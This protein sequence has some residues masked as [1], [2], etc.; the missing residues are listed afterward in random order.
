MKEF[1]EL[2][3]SQIVQF[4]DKVLLTEENPENGLF[5]YKLKVADEDMGVVI[6]KEGRTIRSIRNLMKSKA[7]RDGVRVS[8]DLVDEN[9]P[10]HTHEDA[11]I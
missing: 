11:Q 4:P 2:L 10:Q 9:R 3:V 7:I 6:G 5:L 8:L 1:I